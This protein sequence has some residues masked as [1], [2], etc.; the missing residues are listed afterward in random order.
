[1]ATG[2]KRARRFRKVIQLGGSHVL[3]LPARWITENGVS[4]EDL[5]E[6]DE[7]RGLLIIRPPQH[8]DEAEGTLTGPK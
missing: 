8:H 4:A 3:S 2:G 6:V 5:L 1:M 7:L